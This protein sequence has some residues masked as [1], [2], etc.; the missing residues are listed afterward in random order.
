MQMKPG[1]KYFENFVI[2]LH[3]FTPV[4]RLTIFNLRLKL[5]VVPKNKLSMNQCFTSSVMFNCQQ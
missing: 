4:V 2:D 5:C 1:I 3:L